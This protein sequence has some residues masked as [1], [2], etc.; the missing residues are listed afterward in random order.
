MAPISRG[1]A[2]KV[3]GCSYRSSSR[4]EGLEVGDQ[5]VVDLT[6][7]VALAAAPDLGFGQAFCG[8][9]FDIGT[10]AQAVAHADHHGQVQG[11]VGV[12]I[13]TAVQPMPP[14]SSAGGRD[15]RRPAQVGEGGLAAEPLGVLTGGDEQLAG[16]VVA[17]REQ[18]GGA[19]ERPDRRG[20]LAAGRPG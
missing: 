16:M 17:D 20:W 14:G 1:G 7:E 12:A 8:P 5:G 11:A 13:T 18:L 9:S 4:V 19:G 6:G 15:R 3:P 10:G 2:S